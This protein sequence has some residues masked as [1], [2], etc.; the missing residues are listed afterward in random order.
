MNKGQEQFFNFIMERVTEE[1][2]KEAEELLNESFEKQ[3]NGTFNEE[4][5][6]AFIPKM[7]GLLKPECVE[8]VKNIMMNHKA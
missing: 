6:K 7:L 1:G 8:E 2:R 3:A 4:Y 5:M